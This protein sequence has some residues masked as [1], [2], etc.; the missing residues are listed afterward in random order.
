MKIGSQ[1]ISSNLE[2]QKAEKIMNGDIRSS[3]YSINVE[4]L[5]GENK[6]VFEC[7][8]PNSSHLTQPLDL[9]CFR[10]HKIKWRPGY[11]LSTKYKFWIG[12]S[13]TMYHHHLEYKIQEVVK[14]RPTKRRK[15]DVSAVKVS[16]NDSFQYQEHQK[17]RDIEKDANE[18]KNR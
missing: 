10:P 15:L 11:M 17:T 7:L 2:K 12:S 9:S 13:L 5:C 18:G 1:P 14:P 16:V 8:P 6:I 4:R 3:H